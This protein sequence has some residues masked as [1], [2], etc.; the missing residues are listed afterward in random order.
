VAWM[1]YLRS[2]STVFSTS[3]DS[4]FTSALIGKF[5]FTRIFFDLKP[6]DI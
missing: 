4:A 3:E 1:T 6:A 2:S 5:K